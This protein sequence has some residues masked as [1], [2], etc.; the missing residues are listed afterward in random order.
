[1]Y[2]GVYLFSTQDNA[3]RLGAESNA[4]TKAIIFSIRRISV[5]DPHHKI[6]EYN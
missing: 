4:L 3:L 2:A 1:M 5:I 6:I